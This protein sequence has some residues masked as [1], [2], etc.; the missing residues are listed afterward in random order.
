M[1]AP[2]S[3][4]DDRSSAKAGGKCRRGQPFSTT[5]D[6]ESQLSGMSEEGEVLDAGAA[7]SLARFRWLDNRS[8]LL[9]KHAFSHVL[10]HPACARFKFGGGR[11]GEVRSAA[12]I[13][14][15]NAGCKETSTVFAL[16]A[17][18]PA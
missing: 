2:V 17:G 13:T 4:Q 15:G 1:E 11:L 18:V 9:E 8:Q 14:V 7:A 6:S 16:D 12:D 5:L 10:T 3:V